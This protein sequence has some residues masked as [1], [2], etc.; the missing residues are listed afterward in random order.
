[1]QELESMSRAFF[2]QPVETKNAIAMVNGGRAWRGYFPVGDELTSGKPDV[3]EGIYFGQE[4]DESHPLVQQKTPLHG[5]NQFA[6]PRMREAVLMWMNVCEALGQ[7]LLRGVALGLG[8]AEDYFVQEGL[9]QAPTC[10][11]RIFNYP[12]PELGQY[13]QPFGVQRHS[14][15]GLLT[16]LLQDQCGGL[17]VLNHANEWIDAP[18]LS[19]TFVVNI[20]DMLEKMTLGLY[21]ST[22]H[23]VLNSAGR[24]RISFPFFFD[25]GFHAPLSTLPLTEQ[26]QKDAAANRARAEACGYRRWDNVDLQSMQGTYGDYLLKKV[27]KVFPDLAQNVAANAVTM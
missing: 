16:L 5:R 14:D 7:Q 26:Q 11:F 10:L 27:G 24:D 3:K 18:P 20:G 2:A 1:M 21:R 15:Y 17:Q 6:S 25:P 8:L 13:V 22:Q 9:V 19:D 12:A 4:L 23:R